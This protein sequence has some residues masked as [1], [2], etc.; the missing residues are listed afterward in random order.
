MKSWGMSAE[1]D[2]K[3]GKNKEN[4]YYYLLSRLM[5]Q[6]PGSLDQMAG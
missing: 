6:N 4:R 2:I 3:V 1:R 5:N